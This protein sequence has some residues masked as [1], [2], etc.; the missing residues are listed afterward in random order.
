M[1]AWRNIIVSLQT[2]LITLFLLCGHAASAQRNYDFRSLSTV[3]VK[4]V[5]V[6][7]DSAQYL[8]GKAPFRAIDQVNKA[9]GLCLKENDN[10]NEA[11]AYLILGN[12]QQQLK[13]D[14]LAIENFK[15]CINTVAFSSRAVQ[16]KSKTIQRPAGGS[17]GIT[18]FKAYR[19]MAVSQLATGAVSDANASIQVC[20]EDSRFGDIALRERLEAKRVLASIEFAQGKTQ[21]GFNLLNEVLMLEKSS[22]NGEGETATLLAIGDYYG[23]QNDDQ[24]AVNY[25]YQAQALANANNYKELLL[26]TNEKLAAVF[27]KQKEVNKEVE[28]RNS[29]IAINTSENNTQGILQQ[30]TQIGNAYLATNQLDKAAEYYDKN[31]GTTNMSFSS[32][33]ATDQSADLFE[34]SKLLEDNAK[35]YRTLAEDYFRNGQT[36]KGLGYLQKYA[37]LEDSVQ[38]VRTRELNDAINLSNNIG[39]N[40]QRI[41]LLEKERQLDEKSIEILKQ[42]KELRQDELT[43]R[44]SII[45]TMAVFIMLMLFGGYYM[46][47]NAREKRRVNQ[48]LAI[49]SLRGQMNPHFIFNALNSVNHYIS[50]NDERSANKYLSDFSRLMRSV[51]DSSKHD[52]ISLT[53]EI[54]ILKLYLQLEHARFSDKFN[55]TFHVDEEIDGSEFELPPMMIQP[56]IENAVWHGLRYLNQPGQLDISFTQT[57][58]SL[59]VII[60]DNGIG[61]RKSKEIKTRN[62][63]AQASVGMQNIEQ[64]I[65]IMNELYNT[66]ILVEVQDAFPDRGETG[67]LVKITI[68]KKIEEH[69]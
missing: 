20:F 61:R 6:L 26:T 52:M 5:T 55:Y 30:N 25:Y 34:K 63:K 4:P 51:M 39:K 38:A 36:A 44:N 29:N 40:Q 3:E 27:R 53:E 65:S 16:K 7:L 60:R 35:A 17:G 9:I 10:S 49:K 31:I 64:R 2:G 45:I 42:D 1:K 59:Q 13:Q 54:D 48:L 41:E 22:K 37:T 32:L 12:I 66:N 11:L 62:Q 43:V 19:Q 15:K 33:A 21:D 68:P 18:L 57:N 50:Q 28:L 69:A 24:K 14:E 67:T 8:S 58:E 46:L 47:R 23:K 56:Y